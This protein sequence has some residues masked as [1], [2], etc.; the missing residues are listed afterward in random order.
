M[1]SKCAGD[2]GTRVRGAAVQPHTR[3]AGGPVGGD[4]SGV[5]AEGVG[6]ILRRDAALQRRALDLDH[7]LGESQFVQCAARCHEHLG[8][9]EIDV[10]D[11]L[12]HRVLDLDAGV[13][14][15][16]SVLAGARTRGLEEELHGAR[17]LVVDL[18]CELERVAP[19]RIRHRRVQV[20][21]G[22]DLHDLLM[23]ALDGAVALEEVDRVRVVVGQ[24]LDLDV[25][26]TLHRLLDEDGRVAEGALRL[27]HRR[28]E[29]LEQ[30]VVGV[31][32]AHT[33]P[34]AACHGL[35]EQGVLHVRGLLEQFVDVCR[36]RGR[37]EGR[38]AR[39]TRRLQCM[40]L[41]AGHLEHVSAR[42]HEGDPGLFARAGQ[43]WVLGEE[44]IA[45]VDGVGSRF[46]RHAHDLG[47][48]EVGPDRV[49]LLSDLVRLIGLQP[50]LGVAILVGEHGHGLRAE[51][52]SSAESTDGD[53]ATVGDKH[54]SEH[55]NSF[56][57]AP[58]H[59]ASCG[60]AP[61]YKWSRTQPSGGARAGARPCPW[62]WL[63]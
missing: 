41:V 48:I 39:S 6:G 13:H 9:D 14:L 63:L 51:L 37:V 16:E 5:G 60:T 57:R 61:L 26:R 27:S 44:A 38:N 25:A 11:L 15:D 53:L 50:M 10:R 2:L 20:G 7:V 55:S 34:A 28:L 62:R 59:D 31:D 47:D 19:Q 32:A 35:D 22:C 54:L 4:H 46:L 8:L 3:A 52:V 49:P 21:R 43:I 12:R 42:A 33:A 40:D 23:T 1:E 45:R 17:V 29:R 36:R 18:T 24:H 30:S 56:L 58:V